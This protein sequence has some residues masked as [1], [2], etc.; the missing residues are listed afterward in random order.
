[1]RVHNCRPPAY[2][3]KGLGVTSREVTKNIRHN[4][5]LRMALPVTW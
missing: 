4:A 3:M 1:M 2:T 5:V